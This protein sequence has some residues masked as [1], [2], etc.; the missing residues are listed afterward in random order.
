MKKRQKWR[1]RT[2]ALLLPFLGATSITSLASLAKTLNPVP[3][4]SSQ[5]RLNRTF[6]SEPDYEDRWYELSN[7][8]LDLEANDVN[9]FK[10]QSEVRAL[11]QQYAA[12]LSGSVPKDFLR[13]AVDADGNPLQS[14]DE[15]NLAEYLIENRFGFLSFGD[16]QQ[17]LKAASL[18]NRLKESFPKEF[19]NVLNGYVS[20]YLTGDCDKNSEPGRCA[21]T[22]VKEH[23]KKRLQEADARSR[24]EMLQLISELDPNFNKQLTQVDTQSPPPDQCDQD[25]YRILEALE[26]EIFKSPTV[27]LFKYDGPGAIQR[28]LHLDGLS[29]LKIKIERKNKKIT[30]LTLQCVNS[31]GEMN[32]RLLADPT[33]KKAFI[34]TL[35]EQIHK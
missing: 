17:G 31:R 27:K 35:N 21:A 3:T 18:L 29:S 2:I 24:R 26:K 13:N 28:N 14:I 22:P 19:N 34:D 1:F 25:K 11:L 12:D 8:L 7:R 6:A 5:D 20:G 15:M 30:E 16:P 9:F 10:Y 32:D 4:S 23:L 33:E